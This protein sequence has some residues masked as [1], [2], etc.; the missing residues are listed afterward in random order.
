MFQGYS[1]RHYFVIQYESLRFMNQ[2]SPFSSHSP[3]K[4]VHV[5]YLIVIKFLHKRNI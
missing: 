3:A 1:G 2:K 4:S 5:N